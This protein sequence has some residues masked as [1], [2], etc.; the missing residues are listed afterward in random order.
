MTRNPLKG[1][2][3]RLRA[4]EPGDEPA[5]RR[6]MNDIEVTQ[7]INA[8]YPV[9][10]GAGRG[11][12]DPAKAPNHGL[13]LFSIETVAGLLVGGCVLECVAP[14]DRA[15]YLG[16]YIGEAAYRDGGYGTDAMRVLCRLGFDVMNLHRIGL[17]VFAT[18]ER[19]IHVYEKIGFAVEVRRRDADFRFGV[20]RDAIT[21]GLL[22]GEL[23]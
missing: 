3:V 23:R 20:Y 17:E 14:E 7:H 19:A 13:S 10:L 16:I 6:W 12:I 22:E 11:H 4:R 18:N 1:D 2:L 9:A 21:M 8:R 5:W 15:G